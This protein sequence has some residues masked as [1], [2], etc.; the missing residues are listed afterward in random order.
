MTLYP[1]EYKLAPNTEGLYVL[2][3]GIEELQQRQTEQTLKR[4]IEELER[5]MREKDAQL[6]HCR[7]V[8][9]DRRKPTACRR[10][11]ARKIKVDS[12]LP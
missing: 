5:E 3:L 10:C 8:L 2:L 12:D 7:S 9:S 6:E 4:R 11:K 1:Q